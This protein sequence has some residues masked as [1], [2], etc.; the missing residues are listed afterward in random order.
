MTMR[1]R[2]RFQPPEHWLQ[3]QKLALGLN[4]IKKICSES[5]DYQ[6]LLETTKYQKLLEI[7]FDHLPKPHDDLNKLQSIHPATLKALVK[8]NPNFIGKK[9]KNHRALWVTAYNQLQAYGHNRLSRL[10]GAKLV[11]NRIM[12]TNFKAPQ[13]AKIAQN[14]MNIE[15]SWPNEAIEPLQKFMEEVRNWNL[16]TQKRLI[17]LAKFK[18]DLKCK[19]GI[20]SLDL[21]ELVENALLQQWFIWPLFILEDEANEG[22]ALSVPL[23]LDVSKYDGYDP[24]VVIP[25]KG[26][27]KLDKFFRFSLY[28]ARKAACE[29]WKSEHMSWPTTFIEHI[30]SLKMSIDLTIGELITEP[31]SKFLPKK[32]LLKE[33]SAG[34]YFALAILSKL[35]DPTALEGVC[36]TGIINKYKNDP[37]GGA[38]HTLKSPRKLKGK[39]DYAQGSYLFDEILI[40]PLSEQQGLGF[41]EQVDH[42]RVMNASKRLSGAANA[43]FRQKWRKH[44]YVRAP[45]LAISFNPKKGYTGKPG[46]PKKGY[47]GAPPE[48]AVED[49]LK[50]IREN[51]DPVLQLDNTNP[52]NVAKALYYIS[53][54]IQKNAPQGEKAKNLGTYA[55]IRLVENERDDRFWQTLW[56]VINGNIPSLNDFLF[57]STT[58]IAAGIFAKEMNKRPE[59]EP[60][61]APDVLVLVG[62]HDETRSKAI[63]NGPFAR[64]SIENLKPHLN[65]KLRQTR[66]TTLRKHLSKTRLIL[67]PKDKQEIRHCCQELENPPDL[68]DKMAQLSV[69]RFGFTQEMAKRMWDISDA[70]CEQ[71]LNRGVVLGLLGYAQG[72]G[73]HIVRIK[74]DN[75]R[76]S[77]NDHCKAAQAIVSLLNPEPDARRLNLTESLSPHW[78][79]EAQWH[80]QE[81]RQKGGKLHPVNFAINRL[82]HLGEWFGWT[83]VNWAT[84]RLREQRAGSVEENDELIKGSKAL[85]D[86]S[87]EHFDGLSGKSWFSKTHPIDFIFCATLASELAKHLPEERSHLYEKRNQFFRKANERITNDKLYKKP[88]KDAC[89]YV[90][91]TSMAC[92]KIRRNMCQFCGQ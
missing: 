66:V 52:H 67:V 84:R 60:W 87:F 21:W 15:A 19:C 71:L 88:E 17:S 68:H 38:D 26:F 72:S 64:H 62:S 7:T 74:D 23:A 46:R 59:K 36:A 25:E 3:S 29:L 49:V 53:H 12:T 8:I 24:V 6:K 56:Q 55:F 32:I 86:A 16:P 22:I 79:H 89:S 81:I 63:P 31:Y 76:E 5:P 70:E 51:K 28:D 9:W 4:V 44:Q 43:V 30:E 80:L 47:T 13:I 65:C 39:I 82:D 75:K 27:F 90:L 10:G 37:E 40:P 91:Q 18:Q 85:L 1:A 20:S 45:D 48:P 50:K 57:A 11:A 69:F 34:L 35:V 58:E 77:A 42:L 54:I 2:R 92:M 41:K 78:L 33:K 83:R 61:R 73:E 14:E